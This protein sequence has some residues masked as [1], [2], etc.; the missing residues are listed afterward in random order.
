MLGSAGGEAISSVDDAL[1]Q[2]ATVRDAIRLIEQNAGSGDHVFL[3]PFVISGVHGFG[4]AVCEGDEGI[5]GVK[6]D[7]G[8]AVG[9]VWEQADDGSRGL[10]LDG[11]VAPKN[12]WRVVASIYI[13][14]DAGA[15][16]VLGVEE[17]GVTVGGRGLVD[18]AV[19]VA[20]QRGE[21]SGLQERCATQAGAKAGH[22]EGGGDAL[23]GDVAES[24][25]EAG[26][27]RATRLPGRRKKS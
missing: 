6:E 22:E 2:L 14:E 12:D 13:G 27:V 26:L 20:H 23:A 17:G 5:A 19:D 8:A 18:E 10:K 25:G 11:L 15:R 9:D 21:I 16:I 7:I 4:D 1:H 3:S 24:E